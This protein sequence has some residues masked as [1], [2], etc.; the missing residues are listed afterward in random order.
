[1]IKFSF[2]SAVRMGAVALALLPGWQILQ[3]QGY[4]QGGDRYYERQPSSSAERTIEDLRRISQRETFSHGGHER[5]EHAIEHLS[6]FSGKLYAGRFDRGKLDRSI[7]DVRNVLQR[8]RMDPRA[9]EVL[10]SDLN[11]LYRFRSGYRY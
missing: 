10:S 2:G 1:M 5:Y 8:N 11:E 7:D 4:P 9:R 6:Q 3:A